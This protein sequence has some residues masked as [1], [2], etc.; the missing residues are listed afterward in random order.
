MD[1][2]DEYTNFNEYYEARLKEI[3]ERAN[4]DVNGSNAEF[5]R[6][7]EDAG[8]DLHT[9]LYKRLI[10]DYEELSIDSKK[11]LL[12]PMG[13]INSNIPDAFV[14]EHYNGG[15]HFGLNYWRKIFLNEP[16]FSMFY[17][18]NDSKHLVRD[19]FDKVRDSYI[20]HYE[21]TLDEHWSEKDFFARLEQIKYL[22][23]KYAMDMETKEI[24]A[25]GFFGALVKSGAGGEALTDAE[26]YVM[27]EFRKLGIAKKLV[28]L[29]FELARMN[30]IENFDSVTYRVQN[31][32]SLAFWNS[33]GAEVSGLIHIEGNI[34]E[35]ID[36]INKNNKLKK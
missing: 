35:M 13:F 19:N 4:V 27:P 3:Y 26:L 21:T 25:V 18:P 17:Y 7:C 33:V 16:K 32:D 1:Y 14:L 8:I 31:Q 28:N 20:N 29:S 36:K 10:D 15:G 11:Y 6:Y 5:V 30:G 24:F 34:P 2:K 22:S 12:L 9:V 23:V